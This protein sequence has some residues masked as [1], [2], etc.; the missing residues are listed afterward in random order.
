M[1]FL[2]SLFYFLIVI[3]ILVNIH[4]LGH[5]FAA[6]L[7]GM[8]AD[9]FSFGM[10]KRLF[11]YNTRTGFTFGNLDEDF[12]FDGLTDYRFSLL[13]IG[14]YV[15]IAGMVD[16]SM[17]NDFVNSTPQPWEFRSKNALQK[18]FVLSA[19]VIMNFI[20]A[21]AIYGTIIF[22]SGDQVINSTKIGYI[23]KNSLAEKIGFQSGDEIKSIGDKKISNWN[24][25]L[26][27]LTVKNVEGNQTVV[28]NRNGEN[29]KLTIA[30]GKIVKA[31]SN[32]Q[33][34]GID[35]G[36]QKVFF[37]EVLSLNAAGKAGLQKNDTIKL[38][39]NQEIYSRNQVTDI[40]KANKQKPMSFVYSRKGKLDSTTV[41]TEKDGLLGV[42][43]STDFIGKI[44]TK[45][46]G[47][48][49]AT[50]YGFNHSVEMINMIF[51]SISQI[52][53]GNVDAKQA[54]GGPIMIAKSSAQTAEMGWSSFLK[55]VAA[56]SL[57]L[58]LM[59][60]L[61]FPALDG[62]HL[63]IVIIEGIIR[64]E[65]PIKVKM[66]IQQ[67]GVVILLLLMVAIFYLDLTR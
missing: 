46:Y 27:G 4:E 35:L 14:G 19:G 20:L 2:S 15:K 54:I 37:S 21:V 45:E 5:F 44:T 62:G 66:I 26:Q 56:L 67:I 33:E 49:E 7:T 1:E 36:Q 51:S 24:E 53:K 8:R 48:V 23:S 52:F 39:N 58:A 34:L 30:E 61:P 47:V 29:V 17:D 60:I 18:A 28:V 64:R 41:T 12:A 13:P 38:I 55:F 32:K 63:I 25:V 42:Y 6:R 40:V 11:G 31:L 65:L 57:S 3:G 50:T 22:S 59:N 9:I 16:E 43:L 10:G